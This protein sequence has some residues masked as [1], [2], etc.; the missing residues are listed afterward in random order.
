MSDINAGNLSNL[1]NYGSVNTRGNLPL[2][3][4]GRGG[5]GLKTRPN[6]PLYATANPVGKAVQAGG[7]SYPSQQARRSSA[8][9]E[10]REKAWATSSLQL[11]PALTESHHILTLKFTPDLLDDEDP[12]TTEINLTQARIISIPALRLGRFKKVV[13]LCFRQNLLVHIDG[14]SVIASTLQ[15]LD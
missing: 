14:L 6:F 12:D 10:V 7:L 5:D 13:Q 8:S 2:P 11:R 9:F 15:D 1:A 3:D 4:N